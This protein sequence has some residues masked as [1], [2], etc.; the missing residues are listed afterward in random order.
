MLIEDVKDCTHE[1]K[2][3]W[4]PIFPTSIATKKNK[5]SSGENMMMEDERR[6]QLGTLLIGIQFVDENDH[7]ECAL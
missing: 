5:S 2:E 4:V 1:M 3:I 7:D 6:K